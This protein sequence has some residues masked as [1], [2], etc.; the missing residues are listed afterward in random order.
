LHRPTPPTLPSQMALAVSPATTCSLGLAL[1][2]RRLAQVSG[3]TTLPRAG[4]AV[5][6]QAPTTY[7]TTPGRSAFPVGRRAKAAPSATPTGSRIPTILGRVYRQQTCALSQTVSATAMA[8]A[9]RAIPVQ[10]PTTTRPLVASVSRPSTVTATRVDPS[11][12][13]IST[14]LGHA[15]HHRNSAPGMTK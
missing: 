9:R 1:S 13:R 11:T 2:R 8:P 4:T 7:P 12:S 6:A 14:I 5:R 10:S 3:Q 15:S